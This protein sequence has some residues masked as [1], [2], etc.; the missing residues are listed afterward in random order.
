MPTT[1][2]R[3]AALEAQQQK[4]TLALRQILEAKLTGANGAAGTVV[5]LEGGQTSIDVTL[6][7][8][9]GE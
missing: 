3:L 7:E 4:Q 1:E 9:C 6:P 5:A 2:E 8:L